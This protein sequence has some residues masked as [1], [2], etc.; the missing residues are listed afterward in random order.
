MLP[1][2][3]WFWMLAISLGAAVTAF[4]I[5]AG[6]NVYVQV[7]GRGVEFRAEDRQKAADTSVAERADIGGRVDSITGISLEGGEPQGGKIEVAKQ[8]NISGAFGKI[9]GVEVRGQPKRSQ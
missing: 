2:D 3:P 9:I 8:A 5:W 4:A 6:R 1:K 7:S